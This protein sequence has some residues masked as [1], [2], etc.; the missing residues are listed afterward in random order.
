MNRLWRPHLILLFWRSKRFLD[1]LF[2][3]S[4]IFA[5][6]R[7]LAFP[8]NFDRGVLWVFGELGLAMPWL[9]FFDNHGFILAEHKL[10]CR[11]V[12]LLV[13]QLKHTCFFTNLF[14]F[15]LLFSIIIIMA[16][17]SVNDSARSVRVGRHAVLAIAAYRPHRLCSQRN[18]VNLQNIGLNFKTYLFI[19]VRRFRPTLLLVINRVHIFI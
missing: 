9:T 2:I 3:G 10:R 16:W 15:S 14:R 7:F 1:I 19:F 12:F 4:G 18:L 17:A 5:I 6:V 11:I 13:L 8:A